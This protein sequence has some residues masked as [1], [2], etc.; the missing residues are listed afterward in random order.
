ML[1]VC[2]LQRF[3][4]NFLLQPSN[5]PQ[6]ESSF[7]KA[8]YKL[9]DLSDH[10]GPHLRPRG[11]CRSRCKMLKIFVKMHCSEEKCENH[12]KASNYT[13]SVIFIAK[14]KLKQKICSSLSPKPVLAKSYLALLYHRFSHTQQIFPIFEISMLP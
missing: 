7:V 14:A 12:L 8:E 6:H 4:I 2:F 10:P 1:N 13:F 3:E 9:A 5:K 11:C